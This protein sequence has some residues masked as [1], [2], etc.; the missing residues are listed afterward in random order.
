MT[1]GRLQSCL[2]SATKE[3][4]KK[5]KTKIESM[6]LDI[7]YRYQ[8]PVFRITVTVWRT[9][10][11]RIRGVESDLGIEGNSRQDSSFNWLICLPF[12]LPTLI[13]SG[14]SLT[15]LQVKRENEKSE[16]GG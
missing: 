7:V 13:G 2:T 4:E 9:S 16:R 1:E 12:Y 8:I 5:E 15:R 14:A 6:H 3:I 11:A 10:N